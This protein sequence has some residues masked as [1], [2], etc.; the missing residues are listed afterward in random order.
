RRAA[1]GRRACDR[2]APDR[3]PA[4][5]PT[6]AAGDQRP[7]QLDD[8]LPRPD[9]PDQTVPRARGPQPYRHR[10]RPAALAPNTTSLGVVPEDVGSSGPPWRLSAVKSA[11]MAGGGSPGGW[12][13]R[14]DADWGGRGRRVSVRCARKW[15]GRYRLE[16]ELG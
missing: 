1:Q 15:V 10:R 2:E 8:H 3:A 9:R 14:L 11:G 4:P 7:K 16:G 13:I 12:L 5:L 6:D